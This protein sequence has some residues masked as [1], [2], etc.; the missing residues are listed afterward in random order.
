MDAL[1][2]PLSLLVL[3]ATFL[4]QHFLLVVTEDQS[5]YAFSHLFQLIRYGRW[6]IM[7]RL[8][9]RAR[10]LLEIDLGAPIV[11]CQVLPACNGWIIHFLVVVTEHRAPTPGIYFLAMTRDRAGWHILLATRQSEKGCPFLIVWRT[12]SLN[13]LSSFSQL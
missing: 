10:S 3:T 4:N 6:R 8:A 1:R 7:R 11:S 2:S 9:V 5:S 12:P 13:Q